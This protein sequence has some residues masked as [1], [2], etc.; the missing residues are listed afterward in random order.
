MIKYHSFTRK[1]LNKERKKN[2][3]YKPARFLKLG[4]EKNGRCC[5]G[6]IVSGYT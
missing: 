4:K 1:I 6:P 2:L 5:V 3:L